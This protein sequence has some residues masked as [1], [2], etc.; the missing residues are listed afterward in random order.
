MTL[1]KKRLLFI[2]SVISL[3]ILFSSIS[4]YVLL[5]H[6]NGA[7]RAVSAIANRDDY[8]AYEKTRILRSSV[9][10]SQTQYPLFVTD[11]DK[12]FIADTTLYYSYIYI[13]EYAFDIKG[14]P[15]LKRNDYALNRLKEG[16]F[17]SNDVNGL[18]KHN[19]GG[20]VR[21]RTDQKP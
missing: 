9:E 15:F 14:F 18:A 2:V 21:F 19:A 6:E 5:T 12:R 16:K 20:R 1:K 11:V 3:S 17:Y 4:F 7:R 13:Y 8:N 10:E